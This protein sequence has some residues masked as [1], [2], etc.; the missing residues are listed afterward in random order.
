MLTVSKNPIEFLISIYLFVLMSYF[1]MLCASCF[2]VNL[3]GQVVFIYL[4]KNSLL[5]AIK[6]VLDQII[7]NNY[8]Y[9]ENNIICN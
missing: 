2:L 6:C 9:Y 4:G 3:F 8:T 5:L 1:R 7:N